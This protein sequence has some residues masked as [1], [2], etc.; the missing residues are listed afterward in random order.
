MRRV[1]LEVIATSADDCAL[2][3]ELGGDRIELTCS[4]ALGGLTPSPGLLAESRRATRLP[5]MAMA[6]PREAGFCYS[7]RELAAMLHDVEFLLAHGADGVV[8]G[9]LTTDG[10]IDVA[11]C[12]EVVALA[13]RKQTVFHRAFDAIPNP[14]TGLEQL[15][16]LGVTRVLTSGQAANALA[17]ARLIAHLA[18]Q[19]RNRMEILPGGGVT[20]ANVA[21]LLAATACTQVHV[22]LSEMAGDLS[23]LGRSQIGYLGAIPPE[24]HYRRASRS[25]LETMTRRLKAVS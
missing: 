20:S 16:D 7:R 13:A 3:E 22:S 8:F 9:V 4:L 23:T 5:I 18:E 17:G 2:I 11:A 19:A 21:E 15:I 6:R 24:G 25:A 12:K 1:L 14:L 10:E